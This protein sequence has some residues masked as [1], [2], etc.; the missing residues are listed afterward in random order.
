MIF[1]A[2]EAKTANFNP[3]T[4][5]LAPVPSCLG[6]NSGASLITK[7]TLTKD[8]RHASVLEQT[9]A[10]AWWP[11]IASRTLT[12]LRH[13]LVRDVTQAHNE[14]PRRHGIISSGRNSPLPSSY[15]L[16][17]WLQMRLD[18]DKKQI[19]RATTIR[20]P[21]SRPDRAAALRPKYINRSA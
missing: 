2:Y 9:S 3:R 7:Q 11:V 21:T 13:W 16:W 14:G 19:D 18:L 17:R 6:V 5:C 20:R 10:A 12:R 1:D 8:L 4:L 15:R